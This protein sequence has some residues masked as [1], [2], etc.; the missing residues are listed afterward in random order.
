YLIVEYMNPVGD[1]KNRGWYRLSPGEHKLIGQTNNKYFYYYAVS[2]DV[3][4][5]G[6]KILKFANEFFHFNEVGIDRYPGE[7]ELILSY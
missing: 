5:A 2:E 6:E 3:E 4:W 1:W 7:F